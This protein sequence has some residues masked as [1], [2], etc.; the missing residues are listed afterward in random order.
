MDITQEKLDRMTEA[1]ETKSPLAKA[2][3]E[4]EA[5]RIASENRSKEYLDKIDEY[6]N[7]IPF[8]M[9]CTLWFILGIFFDMTI[10]NISQHI[11]RLMHNG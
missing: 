11:G 1:I 8:W 2:I 7:R 6:D 10:I 5:V 3:L 9:W 4:D